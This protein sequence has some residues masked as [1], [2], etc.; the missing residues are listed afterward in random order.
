MMPLLVSAAPVGQKLPPASF[1]MQQKRAKWILLGKPLTLLM[2][3]YAYDTVLEEKERP[4]FC[5]MP[6][7]VAEYSQIPMHFFYPISQAS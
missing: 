2:L 3:P 1:G 6:W 5:P 7:Q 4:P